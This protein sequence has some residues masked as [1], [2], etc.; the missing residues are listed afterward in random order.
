MS[1]RMDLFFF[2]SESIDLIRDTIG[3]MDRGCF[4]S[5]TWNRRIEMGCVYIYIYTYEVVNVVIIQRN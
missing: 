4:A 5:Q 1:R 3:E 2:F